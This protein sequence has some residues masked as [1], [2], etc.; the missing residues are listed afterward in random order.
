M[1][2]LFRVGIHRILGN[3]FIW[4]RALPLECFET[5]TSG[6]RYDTGIAYVLVDPKYTAAADTPT[7]TVEGS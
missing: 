1:V 5:I 6:S 7:L 2:R 3:F 4:V